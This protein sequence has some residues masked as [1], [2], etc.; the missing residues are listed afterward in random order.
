M[1]GVRAHVTIGG[2]VPGP[3]LTAA[4]SVYRKAFAEAPYHEP[5]SSADRFA[6]RVRR[7]FAEREGARLAWVGDD[8][9]VAAVALGVI[10]TPGTFWVDRVAAFL[11]EQ[12]AREWIGSR[13][14]EVVHVAVDPGHRRRGFGRMVLDLMTAGAPAR[15]AL[16]GCDPNAPAAR[17]LYLNAGWQPI[18]EDFA[19]APGD[20]PHWVMAKPLTGG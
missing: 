6:D 9:E 3:V 1:D 14:F 20:I 4:T 2:E 12:A 10:G 5:P 18:A 19:A 13:C 15:T 16:L 7:Y 11:T 17:G 8:A